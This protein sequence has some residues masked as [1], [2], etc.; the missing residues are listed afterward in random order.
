MELADHSFINRKETYISF[1]KLF[2][3][4]AVSNPFL[5]PNCWR[6]SL[7]SG[8][9]DWTGGQPLERPLLVQNTEE[10]SE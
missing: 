7:T 3:G 5:G 6:S 4:T 10:S 1:A 2:N 8:R 9:A